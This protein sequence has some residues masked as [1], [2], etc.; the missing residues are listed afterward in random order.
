MIREFSNKDERTVLDIWLRSTIKAHP[1]IASDFWQSK[2]SEMRTRY[3]P[4]SSTYVFEEDKTGVVRG[5]ISLIQNQIAALF[6]HPDFQGMRIGKELI[7]FACQKSSSLQLNVYSQN[8]P[9]V[10]FYKRRGFVIIKE[11][12]DIHTGELEMVME[13]NK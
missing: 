3:L 2:V 8:L 4:A 6:V 5:F 9:A 13:Y 11:Q 10:E 7:N 1:F 12:E